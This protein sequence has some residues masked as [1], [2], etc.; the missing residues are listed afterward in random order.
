M[1]NS[2]AGLDRE[3]AGKS[4]SLLDAMY[5]APYT[6]IA[7]RQDSTAREALSAMVARSFRMTPVVDANGRLTGIITMKSLETLAE[8]QSQSAGRWRSSLMPDEKIKNEPQSEITMDSIPLA[9]ISWLIVSAIIFYIGLQTVTMEDQEKFDTDF[10][11][12]V[13]ETE[14][15]NTL[16]LHIIDGT[17]DYGVVPEVITDVETGTFL[18]EDEGIPA[19]PAILF[20][21]LE[22]ITE[23]T[24]HGANNYDCL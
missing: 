16:I 4:D 17:F 14:Q 9:A 8:A 7:V 6:S 24:I 2:K 5:E 19:V 10:A 12:A 1:N 18:R 11:L 23:I 15:E 3:S 21:T 22:S 20:G 13:E